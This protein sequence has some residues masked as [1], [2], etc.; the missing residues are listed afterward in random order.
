MGADTGLPIASAL[1]PNDTAALTQTA[2][3]GATSFP[4][5]RPRQ[6]L[7]WMSPSEKLA[8]VLE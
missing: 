4:N 1:V 2:L 6:P 3:D 8:E 7:H 5:E